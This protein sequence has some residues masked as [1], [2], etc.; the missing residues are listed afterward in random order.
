MDGSAAVILFK[1]A[2]GKD[3]NVNLVG[4]GHVD[5]VL[6]A[7]SAYIKGKPML[8]VDI[9]PESYDVAYGLSRRRDVFV[10]DHHASAKK[11]AEL[12]GYTI[13]LE[14]NACGSEM[15]REWLVE[16]GYKKFDEAS[17]KRFTSY[18]DDHDRWLHRYPFSMKMARL[19]SFIGQTKFIDWFSD[20]EMRFGN[21]MNEEPFWEIE[22]TILDLVE[23]NQERRFKTQLKKF[24]VK[25]REWNGKTYKFAYTIS[26]EVNCS[27]FLHRY[28]N[29][30]PHVD[31]AV[32]L[33]PDVGKVSLR[34]NGRL[35][36][37][38]YVAKWGGGGHAD[39]GGQ[40][41]PGNLTGLAAELLHG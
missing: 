9:S 7:S 21:T 13:N 37:N 6:Q 25:D 40:D 10:I 4:A 8:L 12:S 3:K 22:R 36:I 19:F 39:A 28:L 41:L 18:V 1:A 20:V 23:Y 27:E 33:S 34:S 38:E 31:V 35:P 32:Q 29:E 24:I 17:W 30:N 14:N 5:E 16:G 15:F 11:W 2:G 26:G